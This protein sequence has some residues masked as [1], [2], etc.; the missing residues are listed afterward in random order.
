MNKTIVYSLLALVVICMTTVGG[1]YVYVTQ[2]AA[3]YTPNLLD[4]KVLP[5]E[6]VD[7]PQATG[8]TYESLV[9]DTG[10][11][12]SPV[13]LPDLVTPAL[14]DDEELKK[15]M[16]TF[17]LSPQEAYA[18]WD[19]ER[20]RLEALAHKEEDS[21]FLD[22]IHAMLLVA[23]G[24]DKGRKEAL[25]IYAATFQN[26]K[27]P[28][29]MRARVAS[30]MQMQLGGRESADLRKMVFS[31]PILGDIP[32]TTDPWKDSAELLRKAVAI[33]PLAR[34][35]F[36]LIWVDLQEKYY[37]DKN[38][39]LT[40]VERTQFTERIQTAEK[41]LERQMNAMA[42][43]YGARILP[44]IQK[45]QAYTM[46]ESFG[47]IEKGSADTAFNEALTS[48]TTDTSLTHSE[49]VRGELIVRIRYAMSLAHS[50]DIEKMKDILKAI[51]DPKFVRAP[52]GPVF[53]GLRDLATNGNA[54]ERAA[55]ATFKKTSPFFADLIKKY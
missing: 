8:D 47:L 31:G 17:L 36:F 51:R 46:A 11:T 39:V 55:I 12:K 34:P 53:S 35:A 3:E 49:L 15:I 4:T 33:Y 29:I 21:L 1:F 16:S 22:D 13:E 23:L 9:G 50:G 40:T 6:H 5:N 28:P 37:A 24:T 44:L 52:F 41:D 38:A 19:K 14:R 43:D 54:Y 18:M 42:V 45:G 27:T 2:D 26:E 32:V 10:I 7:Y 30:M 48:A 20:P 25:Q